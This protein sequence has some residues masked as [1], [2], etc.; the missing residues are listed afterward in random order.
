MHGKTDPMAEAERWYA[1]LK[2]PDCLASERIEF[3]R[4]LATPENAA[5]FAA[6]EA[7]WESLQKLAGHAEFEDLSRR[8]LAE[9]ARHAPHRHR[10]LWVASA[11]IALLGIGVA[12]WGAR[13]QTSPAVA[14]STELGERSTIKLGDGSLLLLNTATQLEASLSDEA[15]RITLHR[16]E[17]LFTAARDSARPFTVSAG[18]GDIT[19][20]GTK[21]QV[22]NEADQVTVTLIEGRVAIH[23]RDTREHVQLEP[24]D[25]ARFAIGQPGVTLRTVDLAVV[26][27]WSTGR[28]RFRATPLGEVI[29]EVNRYSSVKIRVADPALS[30]IPVSG[31]FEGGDSESVLAALETLLGVQVVRQSDDSVLLQ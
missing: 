11:L 30:R 8:I 12:F 14:Y 19:A 20:L 1:R 6:T 25:Q 13:E 16:G 10:G 22:R 28:L 7:R 4:W 29:E 21:F 2:A 3:R 27:S 15:R 5:A 9:T 26:T 18:D 24:G 23:R 17:A 31:T